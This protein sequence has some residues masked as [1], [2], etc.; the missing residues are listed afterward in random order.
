MLR[1]PQMALASGPVRL[2][3]HK[4]VSFESGGEL[5][6]YYNFEILIENDTVVGHINLRVGETR[7]IQLVAGHVGFE[8]AEEH[9]DHA[10]SLH[11]C[12]ALRP[13]I[14]KHCDSVIITADPDNAA[15]LH[16]IERLGARF[17]SEIEVP[18]DDP[19]YASGARRKKR[20]EWT[21]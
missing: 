12:R 7:H 4:I 5:V 19:A 13:L 1:E 8:I 3:F 10:Y 17:L 18:T 9:R 21:L 6:P 11:A 14:R 20:F 2:R 16:I 15:S